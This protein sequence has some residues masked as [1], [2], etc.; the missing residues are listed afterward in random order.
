[1]AWPIAESE[2]GSTVSGYDPADYEQTEARSLFLPGTSVLPETVKNQRK[3]RWFETVAGVGDPQLD[4]RR[5]TLRAK[6]LYGVT[7]GNSLARYES[8]GR[9]PFQ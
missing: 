2:D 8:C 9:K 1:M 4:M 7:C 3:R 5:E 6:P